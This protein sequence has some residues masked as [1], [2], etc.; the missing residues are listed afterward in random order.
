MNVWYMLGIEANSDADTI[1]KAYAQKIRQFHPEEHPQEFQ[2]L[3][4][5]Y[6]KALAMASLSQSQRAADIDQPVIGPSSPAPENTVSFDFTQKS[7]PEIDQTQTEQDRFDFEAFPA[8]SLQYLERK[9][10]LLFISVLNNAYKLLSNGNSQKSV[11]YAFLNSEDFQHVMDSPEFIDELT[12]LLYKDFYTIH[13][14]V[15]DAIRRA[16]FAKKNRDPN[17]PPYRQLARLLT[18]LKARSR[19]RHP[20]RKL[21]I[22]LGVSPIALV[23]V[24]CIILL[25]NGQNGTKYF[26]QP[27]PES[28]P[29]VQ[30]V[31]GPDA[32]Q[33]YLGDK[34]PDL[35]V[36]VSEKYEQADTGHIY[37]CSLPDYGDLEFKVYAILDTADLMRDNLLESAFEETL[38]SSGVDGAYDMCYGTIYLPVANDEELKTL[39]SILPSIPEDYLET[40][41]F[42]RGAD[43]YFGVLPP[44]SPYPFPNGIPR[45]ILTDNDWLSSEAS[46][47]KMLRRMLDVFTSD[48]TPWEDEKALQ[49]ELSYG[50]AV[51]VLIDGEPH[52]FSDVR[53]DQGLMTAGS[54][55]RLCLRLD[56]PV[57]IEPNGDFIIGNEGQRIV[58]SYRGDLLI[59]DVS[60]QFG[61]TFASQQSVE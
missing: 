8:E 20:N 22:T 7:L 60:S 37:T 24:L 19:A 29:I 54:A 12:K 15:Y 33:L 34:Y 18:T 4:E 3:N 52:T 14:V 44:D 50:A 42:A 10:Q 57:K 58:F 47:L 59:D 38:R 11:W 26:P 36:E 21:N 31:T 6:R 35:T 1:R 9:E 5:A 46:A 56:I 53:V 23:L 51:T 49:Y 61:I 2:R 16:Y 48:Y 43:L 28:I 13:P 45:P 40:Y 41:P 55:Y 39:A 32:V 17:R 27:T 25:L 30:V